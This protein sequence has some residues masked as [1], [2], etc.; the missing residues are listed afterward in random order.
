MSIEEV[1][2][3]L[4]ETQEGIEYQKV[5]LSVKSLTFELMH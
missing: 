5:S 3:I 1:E 2:R 4:E